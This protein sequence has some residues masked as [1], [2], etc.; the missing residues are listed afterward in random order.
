MIIEPKPCI[1]LA[2]FADAKAIATIHV[3]SWQETYTG[4]LPQEMLERLSVQNRTARWEQL[5]SGK[6]RVLVVEAAGSA[7]GFASYGAQRDGSLR[8]KGFTGEIEAIYLLKRA[9]RQGIGRHLMARIARCLRNDGHDAAALWVLRDNHAACTFYKSL[10]GTTE[11]EKVDPRPSAAIVEH[12]YG[13]RDL[14]SLS[15]YQC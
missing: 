1:R 11:A 7:V 2:K 14:E 6:L 8:E 10:G 3:A 5:L 4:L 15:S 13:W 12:A 9:Q